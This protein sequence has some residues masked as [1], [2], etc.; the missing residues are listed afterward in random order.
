MGFYRL[1]CVLFLIYLCEPVKSAHILA[2]FSS[3][4]FA[5]HAV[6]RGF[7]T[8]LTQRGHSVVMM[9]PYPGQFQYPALENIVE[10]DVGGESAQYWEEYKALMTNTED[11]FPRRR[12]INEV[13][14]KIVISQLK[15]KQMMALYVNSRIKF[16]L[17]VTDADVPALY[18]A[19]D[20]Y[21]APH[22]ALATSSGKI[23]QHE[24]KGNPVHPILYLDVNSLN[25][26]R[27]M[28]RWQK[29]NEFYRFTRTRAEYYSHYLPL[30][31]LA[32][33]KFFGLQRSLEQVEYD[34]DLLFIASNPILDGN[35]PK[36]PGVIHV[37]RM[38]IKPTGQLT[39]VGDFKRLHFCTV[40]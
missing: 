28:T 35:R 1:C 39:K 10:L 37:D 3:L 40:L 8:L 34:I 16:D 9:T 19:A 18:A 32:G 36:V 17:V 13:L 5:D 24:S 27:N 26:G 15:S 20:K 11:Y 2:L 25:N 7:V 33:Q 23:H 12:A 14:L 30:N 4:S 6:Y 38:H 31:E 29:I 22:I 21:N